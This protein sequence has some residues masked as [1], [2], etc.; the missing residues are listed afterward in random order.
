LSGKLL[1]RTVLR[2]CA[3]LRSNQSGRGQEPVTVVGR[4]TVIE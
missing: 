4:I 3:G 2:L 1:A